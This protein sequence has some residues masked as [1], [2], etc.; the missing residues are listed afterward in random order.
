MLGS[1][2]FSRFGRIRPDWLGAAGV[3][4]DRLLRDR[5][6]VDREVDTAAEVHVVVTALS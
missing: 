1:S 3:A 2:H 5:A 4:V 6:A